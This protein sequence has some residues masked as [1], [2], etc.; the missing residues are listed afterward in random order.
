[1][2]WVTY[3]DD[4]SVQ[5]DIWYLDS[6][7]SSHMCGKQELFMELAEGVHGSVTWEI[8]QNS[9]L[10]AEGRSKS[11][12]WTVRPSIFPIFIIFLT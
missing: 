8:L 10:K 3:Y 1:M 12:K 5:N 11:I 9:S 7:A 4:S 2:M 6:G